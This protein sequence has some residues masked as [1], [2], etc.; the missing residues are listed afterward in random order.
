L[1]ELLR[2]IAVAPWR[3]RL[4]FGGLG[5]LLFAQLALDDFALDRTTLID[6]Q[7]PDQMIVFV[8]HRPRE[9]RLA[10][11]FKHSA[12]HVPRANAGPHPPLDRNVDT[13]K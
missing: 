11:D 7:A 1:R 6:E 13:R 10:V 9:Q 4:G 8:L 5:F 12:I 3:L 2:S